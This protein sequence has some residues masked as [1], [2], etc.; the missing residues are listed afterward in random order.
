M[1]LTPKKF[2]SSV[3][4]VLALFLLSQTVA[5]ADNV[6]I[7]TAPLEGV[8]GS[9]GVYAILLDASMTGDGN[10]TANLT[11]FN[12]G[13]GAPTALIGGVGG[14][15]GNLTSGITLI[16]TD[17][18]GFNS[19]FAGFTPGSTLS[20]DFSMTSNADSSINPMSGLAGDQFLVLIW[21]LDTNS[22]V[23]T[24]D[25]TGTDAFLE[26]TVTGQGSLSVQ[27]YNIPGVGGTTVSTTPE[28]G[29]F[30]LLGAGILLFGLRKRCFAN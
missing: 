16:D 6:T 28:P 18:S 19:L 24:T 9:Y 23:T 10:N 2:C 27:S 1:R 14:G 21:N 15:S 13:G 22:A 11:G 20:F 17:P 4:V 12:L 29:T 30:L 5:S 7:D 26:A 3:L 8:S 25:P